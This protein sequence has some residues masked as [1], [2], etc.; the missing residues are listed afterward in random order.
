MTTLRAACAIGKS[1][2][3]SGMAGAAQAIFGSP[4]TSPCF[5]APEG[6]ITAAV[7]LTPATYRVQLAR[8][9]EDDHGGTG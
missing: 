6:D 1:A 3:Q 9:A 2:H 7:D 4:T 8:T 5:Y